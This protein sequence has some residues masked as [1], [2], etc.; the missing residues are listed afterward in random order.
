MVDDL[1]ERI[2]EESGEDE[3]AIRERIEAK[4]EEMSGLVSEEGAAHLIAREAGVE[5][6][7][8]EEQ[9]MKVEHVVPGMSRMDITVRV[10]DKTDTNTFTRDDG[11][12]GKVRNLVLGDE[13]GTVRMSLWDDQVDIAEKVD[14]GDVIHIS[15]AYTRED[16]RGNPE[17][18][19]GN[20]THIERVDE[21]IEA[22]DPSSGG[23]GGS[24]Q[25]VN[26]DEVIDEN[27]NYA[28]AGT[29][30]ELYT[31]NPFYLACPECQKKVEE[32]GD[33]HAC[34]EHGAVEPQPTLIL[35]AI[36]DDGYDN[37]RTVFFRDRA[38]DL[39]QAED[40]DFDGDVEQVRTHAEQVKGQDVVV[41]GQSRYN[42]Y[43]NRIELIG[44]E[45]AFREP[46]A[47]IEER[48]AEMTA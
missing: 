16:N 2:A 28:V 6:A 3:D 42:D 7:E 35:S 12:E 5:L 29:V 9:E 4:V 17:L 26:I 32:Q 41:K 14:T 37:V 43:F 18:R 15:G 45:V 25:R 44:D 36:I 22:V 8:A 10:V 48:L 1:I 38:K 23:G 31:Q 46:H 13:T 19:I 21:E 40:E 39:L 30:V 20:N 34:G 33:G 24:Y 11:E 47:L 27:V